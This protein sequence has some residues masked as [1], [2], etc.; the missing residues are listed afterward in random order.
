MVAAVGRLVWTKPPSAATRSPAGGARSVATDPR[1]LCAASVPATPSA[2]SDRLGGRRAGLAHERRRCGNV[3]RT[4]AED[5]LQRGIGSIVRVSAGQ[6]LE[7]LVE[8]EVLDE[9]RVVARL[10]LLGGRALGDDRS[11]VE[12]QRR[13]GRGCQSAWESLESR[14]WLIWSATSTPSVG[15]PIFES[16]R[17]RSWPCSSAIAPSGSSVKSVSAL[18]MLTPMGAG[19][20]AA[21]PSS[22]T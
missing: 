3:G 9:P 5:R 16:S 15:A 11:A 20:A 12:R 4:P 7:D 1:A 18:S 8:R 14:A 19:P 21:T 17:E 22:E 2:C 6:P 13:R 10:Q